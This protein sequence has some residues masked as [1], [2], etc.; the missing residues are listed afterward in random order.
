MLGNGLT[1]GT[2]TMILGP[3]GTGKSSICCAF[4]TA[5]AQRGERASYFAFDESRET[6]MERSDSLGL[7]F[8]KMVEK[9]DVHLTAMDPL[10]LLPG[11]F[12][13]MVRH[14]VTERDVKMIVLDSL[15]GY[16]NAMPEE[17]SLVAQLHDLFAYL[18]DR[19]VVTIL[20]MGQHGLF[21]DMVIS[22]LDVSYLV[23]SVIL[24]RF[25]EAFGAISRS[26]S[27]V[28]KRTGQHE[29]L[30]RELT[31]TS[32]AGIVVGAPLENLEGI[33]GGSPHVMAGG[34]SAHGVH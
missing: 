19:G 16:L 28:K 20:V 15:T 17:L 11:E 18:G 13:Q 21:G 2:A 31:L 25:F 33:L 14:A 22:P 29:H 30:I 10:D 32:E 3:A 27:V 12:M 23:D 4:A 1:H 24:L 6:I 5:S 7:A 9:G 34:G 8:A 26:I